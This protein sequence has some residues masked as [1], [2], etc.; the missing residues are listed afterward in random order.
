MGTNE[1]RK[2]VRKRGRKVAKVKLTEKERKTE[3]EN[4]RK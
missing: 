2:R 4:G 1:R 3:K